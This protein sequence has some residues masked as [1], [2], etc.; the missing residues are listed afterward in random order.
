M[1][2]NFH[3]TLSQSQTI[4]T[5]AEPGIKEAVC[6][7][8]TMVVS[9]T[10]EK[11]LNPVEVDVVFQSFPSTL[12]PDTF[13]ATCRT[14]DNFLMYVEPIDPSSCSPDCKMT[15]GLFEDLKGYFITLRAWRNATILETKTFD[16][17]PVFLSS[18]HVYTTS[19]TALL[20]W[21]LHKQQSLSTLSL[22]NTH[23]QSVT[24][25][26]NFSTSETKSEYK[27]KGLQ[28]GTHFKI[29]AT[30]VTHLRDLN[31][32]L[33]QRLSISLETAQCPSGWLANERSCLTVRRTGLTWRDAEHS[34]R[35]VAAGS[36]LADLKTPEDL[37]FLGSHLLRYNNLLLLWTGLNDKREEGRPLWSDG[38]AYN[39]TNAMMSSLPANEMDCFA[40][41]RNATGPGYFLT[42]FFC[43]IPL[44]FICQH[45]IPPVPV[46]ITFDLVQV[47]EQ[48]VE[49]RWSDLLVLN[50]LNLASFEIFLQYQEEADEAQSQSSNK[51]VVRVPISLSSRGVTV[52]GL[53][54]GSVYSFTLQASHPAGPAW[55]LAQTQTA[56]TRPLSPLNIT[57]GPITVNQIMVHWTQ[58]DTQ[59]KSSPAALWLN[60]SVCATLGP[61]TPGQTY[62]VGVVSVMGKDRSQKTSLIHT[63]NPLPVQAAIP[64]SVGTNSAQLFIQHPQLGLINGVKV[65]GSEYQLQVHST[66]KEQVGP[67]YYSRPIR[68]GL[69]PPDRVREGVVTE[70]SIE[71]LWDPAQRQPHSYEVICLNCAESVQS[72]CNIF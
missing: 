37:L 34:C 64:L 58:T 52:A 8:V 17:V 33:K 66:S 14:M 61:V 13:T 42:P 30:V 10:C 39:L 48:H 20:T 68:T 31:L 59:S 51:K 9:L 7:E 35:K 24:H 21:K 28:A 3:H 22:F 16:F 4:L 36:H 25:I 47:T 46:H 32:T 57:V 40:L 71:L 18:F 55:S 70:S 72:E 54:P 23:T 38:S 60:K 41:Q 6:F 67:P 69:V 12:D 49:L 45:Q 53:S 56:L 44:P 63:T 29:K 65:P 1:S 27:I 26:F 15:L 50:S 62:E 43:N 11:H 5:A 19:T 2:Q